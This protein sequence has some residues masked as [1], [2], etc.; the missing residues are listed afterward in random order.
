MIGGITKMKA[1][2]KDIVE[3]AGGEFDY[4]D[5]YLK[6][7]NAN[8]EAKVRRSDLVICPVNCNS[9]NACIKVKKLCN[10]YNKELKLLESSSLSALTRAVLV[11]PD[12]NALN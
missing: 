5:G 3:N 4:H 9:H 12:R 8:L 7:A 2:Y 6:N 11:H 1:H 10:R